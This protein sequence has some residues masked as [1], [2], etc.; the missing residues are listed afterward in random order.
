[1]Q[2]LGAYLVSV[3]AAALICGVVKTLIPEGVLG[4]ALKMVTGI[5]MVLAVA[6]PWVGLRL[7]ALGQWT[8]GF[9][10]AAEAAAG[11]G[12]NAAMESLRE[13]ISQQVVAYIQDKAQ[14][15]EADLT[16]QVELTDDALP[17]PRRVILRGQ[18]S[19]YARSV[20]SEYLQ[21]ELCIETEDQIWIT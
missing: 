6:G 11:E 7:P 1:M 14:S 12:S 21:T 16:V 9:Q 2:Q 8:Q 18:I 3:T 15:L 19:P 20:L 17:V 10:Q 4:T 13:S 5:L